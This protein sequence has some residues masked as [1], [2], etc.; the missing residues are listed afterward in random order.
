[1]DDL[2]LLDIGMIYDMFTEKSNDGYDDWR[3]VATQADFDR[4]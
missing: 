4:F 3:Q 1:M 2:D